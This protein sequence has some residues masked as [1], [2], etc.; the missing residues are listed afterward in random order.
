[1]DMF[2]EV[3]GKLSNENYFAKNSGRGEQFPRGPTCTYQ[4]KY[5]PH[6]T[7]Y[8]PRGSITSAILFDRLTTLDLL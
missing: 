4:G 3:E 1:M 6:L 8:I 2:K 5:I 7:R